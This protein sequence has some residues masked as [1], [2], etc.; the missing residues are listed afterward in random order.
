MRAIFDGNYRVD[1][2]MG[3]V[4]D[5]VQNLEENGVQHMGSVNIY[6]TPIQNGHKMTFFDDLGSNVD[7]LRFEPLT[8]NE[9]VPSH[10]GVQPEST[11]AGVS[12]AAKAEMF[13]FPQS[14][15]QIQDKG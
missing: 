10:A 7:I 11:T 12:P 13:F 14:K 2:L 9:F 1:Q 15:S 6:F 8:I 3:L 5:L 4:A